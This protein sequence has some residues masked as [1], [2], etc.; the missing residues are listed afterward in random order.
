MWPWPPRGWPGIVF[1]LI[2]GERYGWG[3]VAGPIG[4]T[5]IIVAG[6]VVLGVFVA[7]Q[8]VQRGEPLMPLRL[9]AGRA[10]A[11]GNWVGFFFQFGMI[12]I[13]FTVVLYLQ[14]ARGYSPMQTGLVLLPGS[15]LTAV[16]SA[17]AGRL[18]DRIGGR[19]VLMAG[20]TLLAAGLVV[21]ALTVGPDSGAWAVLPGLI[22]IGVASGAT[23]A[24]L[25]QAT[26]DG[27]DPRLA[28]AA[29]GV[30]GTVRQIGGVLGTAALGALL[31]AR[32]DQVLRDEAVERAPRLPADLRAEF[33]DATA[34][35]ARRFSPPSAPD[36]LAP[37][38]TALFERLG[39]EAFAAGFVDAMQTALLASAAV[40][41][42]AAL[43]CLLFRTR[44]EDGVPQAVP[45]AE[46]A[47]HE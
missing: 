16:G 35:S 18:S 31:S 40:L 13:A 17:Y 25:Q 24:P 1:G 21:I 27:V 37:A 42:L 34:A 11:V 41:I 32:L 10:F 14:A 39:K 38:D 26:M 47:P 6:F 15:V 22:I 36:G 7:W 12:G 23:F 3:S 5:S 20:L 45:E 43:F 19:V 29:S 44:R 46:V 9:F 28:G 2:E 4:I 33:I 8:H 30:S